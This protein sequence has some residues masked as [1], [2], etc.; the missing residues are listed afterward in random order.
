MISTLQLMNSFKIFVMFFL[1]N[2]LSMFFEMKIIM[3]RLLDILEIEEP[4]MTKIED[5]P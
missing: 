5:A 4:K 2:G 1:G 3:N